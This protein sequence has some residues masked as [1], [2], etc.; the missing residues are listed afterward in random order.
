MLTIDI[1]VNGSPVTIRTALN[2]SEQSGKI[3]GEGLQVYRVCD[4]VTGEEWEL[5]HRFCNSGA[6]SLARA[7]LIKPKAGIQKT[8]SPQEAA[9]R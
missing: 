4:L 6:N 5:S 2:I 7:M 3:Y 1:R 9:P 8:K